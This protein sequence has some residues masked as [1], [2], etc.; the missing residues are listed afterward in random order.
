[1]ALGMLH[2]AW[3]L[4]WSRGRAGKAIPAFISPFP[5]VANC[6]GADGDFLKCI[7]YSKSLTETGMAHTNPA[8]L[9]SHHLVFPSAQPLCSVWVS[10]SSVGQ[11]GTA[12]PYTV[13]PLTT[14]HG[15]V[16]AR[17]AW[18][19]K[20]IP[21]AGGDPLLMSPEWA[22]RPICCHILAAFF[23]F[24]FPI[25][26]FSPLRKQPWGRELPCRDGAALCNRSPSGPPAQPHARN[27]AP[28]GAAK[29]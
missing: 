6:P 25:L 10:A 20:A 3:P 15:A 13:I 26:S 5:L 12:R 4:C 19:W 29:G 24:P 18:G 27:V 17:A 8:P 23:H 9:Q 11:S 7:R 22:P 21:G 16:T 1:M 14:G 2:K 28:R